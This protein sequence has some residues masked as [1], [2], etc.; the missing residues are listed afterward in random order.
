MDTDIA[1]ICCFDHEEVGS[2]SS[3]GAGSPILQDA[4]QRVSVAL[5]GRKRGC[6][7]ENDV[8]N[9]NACLM[10]SPEHQARTIAKSF[11]LSI[12]QAHAI[13]PNYTSK[14]ESNH[15]PTLNSGIVIKTNSNQRYATNSLTGFFVVRV[16][17]RTINRMF[18]FCWLHNY[19]G[20]TTSHFSQLHFFCVCLCRRSANLEKGAVSQCKSLL[21]RLPYFLESRLFFFIFIITHALL[22]FAPSFFCS[23]VIYYLFI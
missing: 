9:D 8:D 3:H 12:D 2:A 11:C 1:M 10:V 22:F 18:F 19:T 20:C 7:G 21:V 15:A 13:H 5:M 4:I 23:R 16:C 14:H 17:T 6:N